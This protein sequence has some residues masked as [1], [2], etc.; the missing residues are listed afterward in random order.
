MN[1]KTLEKANKLAQRNAKKFRR[2]ASLNKDDLHDATFHEFR[3]RFPFFGCIEVINPGCP[4]F[5]M[6]SNHDDLVAQ[7][8]FWYG[9][10]SYERCSMDQWIKRSSNSTVIFDIGA[11]SGVYALSS[12]AINK[13]AEI[14]AFEPTRR[15]YG[16]LLANMQLNGLANQV[17]LINKAISNKAEE[18]NFH[19]YRGE[20]ILGSGASFIDKQIEIIES[21]EKVQ[22]IT[23]DSFAEEHQIKVELMKIDVEEAELMALQGMNGVLDRDGPD[24]LVEVTPE[25]VSEVTSLL[26]KH[27]YKF[28][29]INDATVNISLMKDPLAHLNELL[30]LSSRDRISCNILAER[31]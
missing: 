19:Q 18:V 22:T 3:N 29:S 10:E 21:D 25:T 26:A 11:Y 14:Y 23:I 7:T 16:R 30:R 13:S 31:R 6:Y 15:V 2:K 20:H 5:L 24:I 8:Y 4:P 12:N 9:Q 17:T 1:L 28:Y 27:S